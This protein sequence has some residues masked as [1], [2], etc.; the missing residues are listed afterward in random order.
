M[1][2]LSKWWSKEF[3]CK[4]S[5][6]A[7]CNLCFHRCKIAVD[8]VGLCRARSYGGDRLVSPYL[9]VF[10]SCAIDPIEKKPLRRWMPN[11]SILSLGGIGCNMRCQ[12][13][14]NHVIAQPDAR[15]KMFRLSPRELV[16]RT[17]AHGLKSVAYTYNEP[18]LFAEYILYAAPLLKSEGISTVLVSNGMFSEELADELASSISAVN[19]DIKTFDKNIYKKMGG[20]LDVVLANIKKLV[21]AGVHVEVTSLIVPGISDS[22]DN[23]VMMTEWLAGLSADIPLHIS[24]YFP[25]HRY[26]APP[27]DITLIERFTAHAKTKLKYVYSGNI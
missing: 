4:E 24:R 14:Q 3:D 17:V 27:T 20:S 9:G 10:T 7:H 8:G 25:A 5:S 13:C 2:T 1:Y 26:S 16:E 18:T 22:R 6:F 12:F 15:P 11:T 21:N 19:I 23:F